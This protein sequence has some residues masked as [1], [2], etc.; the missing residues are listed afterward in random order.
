MRVDTDRKASMLTNYSES[1]S[2]LA[3][4]A[5]ARAATTGRVAR[6]YGRLA[7]RNECV[8]ENVVVLFVVVLF[9]DLII[10]SDLNAKNRY[11]SWWKEEGKR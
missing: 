9:C 5:G 3:G 4:V 11:G 8:V 1:W 2:W 6:S 7:E 10:I